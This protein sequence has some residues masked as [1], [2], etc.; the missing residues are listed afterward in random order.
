MTD[1]VTAI[2]VSYN[3][4]DLTV[5]ALR[6]LHEHSGPKL[7]RTIVVDNASDDGSADAIA[8]NC[9][10]VDLVRMQDNIGFARA[11][12]L[13]A[14][15]ATTDHLLLLNPD[16]VV[17]S[18]IVDPLVDFAR[19]HPRG[20]LWGGRTLHPSGAVDPRSCWGLPSPWST[21]C[22]ALGL[23][24]LLKRNPVFDPESLGRW[25]R[26]SER[27][28]GMVSG[29]LLLVRRDLWQQL[30]GF[31]ERYFMYG[32]DADLAFRARTQ[33]WRPAITPTATIV[34]YVGASSPTA[35]KRE[36]V[37]R[38]KATLVR[39]HL[40]RPALHVALLVFGTRLRAVA[41]HLLGMRRPEGR[42]RSWA[43]LAR[44][45]ATW[46]AGW[47]SAGSPVSSAE[48]TGETNARIQA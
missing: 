35:R 19:R 26:D 21:V 12:N 37:M 4:A 42:D 1:T 41:N 14:A 36:L 2:V 5:E 25:N 30:G 22:F 47:P 3:T 40:P 44:Q 7:V 23:S 24:T 18:D 17:D 29:C 34:H 16:V 15:R 31:D 11:V 20:G 39:T 43:P 45:P 28:V 38:A 33:G 32:E 46:T 10:W 6:G 48:P 8:S 13:A 9:P 27:E